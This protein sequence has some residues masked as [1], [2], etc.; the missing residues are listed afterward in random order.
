MVIVVVV[1]RFVMVVGIFDDDVDVDMV[2][3]LYI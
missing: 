1:I 2:Y 3:G